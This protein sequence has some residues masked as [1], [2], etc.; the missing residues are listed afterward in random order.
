MEA[1]NPI[2]KNRRRVSSLLFLNCLMFPRKRLLKEYQ[3]TTFTHSTRFAARSFSEAVTTRSSKITSV[4]LLAHACT[5]SL[6]LVR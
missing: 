3:F 5:Y 4:R 1:R 2:D 6:P